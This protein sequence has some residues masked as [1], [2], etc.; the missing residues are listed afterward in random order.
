[1]NTATRKL[2]QFEVASMAATEFMNSINLSEVP[3]FGI[4]PVQPNPLIQS[5]V[6]ARLT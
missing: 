4:E 5:A 6:T 3:N 1:M 2:T